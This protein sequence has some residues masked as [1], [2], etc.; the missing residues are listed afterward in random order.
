MPSSTA[1]AYRQYQTIDNS[2]SGAGTQWLH[3]LWHIYQY[4]F[5]DAD[6][7]DSG[8]WELL[9]SSP[10]PAAWSTATNV[11]NNSWF[12]IECKT[13]RR[14]WQAKF[15]ATNTVVL[16]EAPVVTYALVV[17][18]SPGGG[19]S[20]KGLANGGFASTS[21]PAGAHIYLGGGDIAGIDGRIYVHGDR[22]TLLVAIAANGNT[23]YDC[24]GY[25]GRFDPFTSAILYPECVLGGYDGTA[26]RGFDRSTDGGAFATSPAASYALNATPTGVTAGSFTPAWIDASHQPD[27][28]SGMYTYR[29]LELAISNAPLGY[30][31]GVWAAAGPAARTRMD[32]R[33][34]LVLHASAADY[35]VAIKH[36]GSV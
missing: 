25:I 27:P 10:A 15:Q 9:D 6:T 5:S 12:A 17:S 14:Q 19:W 18:L 24:G 29:P 22:D 21:V 32:Y 4:L 20:G 36:D 35:A 16:D 13:G 11:V 33:R 26:R 34:K 8:R 2:G 1:Y 3:A 30:L 28:F 23:D 31:R 7:V